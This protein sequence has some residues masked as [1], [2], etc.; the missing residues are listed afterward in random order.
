MFNAKVGLAVS[1]RSNFSKWFFSEQR[2]A[3]VEHFHETSPYLHTT[4][5][6]FNNWL[7]MYSHET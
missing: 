5:E 4:I 2:R 3:N 1:F 7:A 6:L